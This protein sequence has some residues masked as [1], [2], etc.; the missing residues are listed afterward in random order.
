M[1]SGLMRLCMLGSFSFIGVN[2]PVP[3]R[4]VSSSRFLIGA[5]SPVHF[6][7]RVGRG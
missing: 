1:G 6:V 4:D 2:A 3:L 5:S 7:R